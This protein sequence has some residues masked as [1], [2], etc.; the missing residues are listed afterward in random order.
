VQDF[1]SYS[2]LVKP[3]KESAGKIYGHSGKKIGN[4]HLKWAFSEAA[5]SMLRGI[6][7]VKKYK[8]KLARKHGKAKALSILAHKIGR[9]T[10]YI[11]KRKEVFTIEKFLV[12]T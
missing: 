6:P 3:S 7:D 2:R 10:Y 9:A 1:V 4:A 12:K 8:E 11:L 5:L